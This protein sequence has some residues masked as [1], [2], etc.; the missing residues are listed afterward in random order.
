MNWLN[1]V[2]LVLGL[3]VAVSPWI[4]GFSGITTALWSNII[5]GALIAIFAL[6]GLFGGKPSTPEASQ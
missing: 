3:W 6:W 1:W 4:L 5:A 2:K